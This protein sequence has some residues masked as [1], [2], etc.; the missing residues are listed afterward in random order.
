MRQTASFA[1]V[2]SRT[3]LSS[4]SGFMNV[5]FG[6]ARADDG[7]SDGSRARGEPSDAPTT[8]THIQSTEYAHSYSIR[9]IPSRLV[10]L[11]V[12]HTCHISKSTTL[13][14]DI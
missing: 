12:L 11:R 3:T 2:Y 8:H 7:Y 9:Q 4:Q 14:T 13:I 5:R 6:N 10:I 1:A